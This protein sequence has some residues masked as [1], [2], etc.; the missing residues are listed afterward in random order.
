VADEILKQAGESM[1][2]STENLHH[3][4]AGIRTGKANPALLDTVKV[5]YYGQSVPLKQVA[6]IAVP[7]ARLITVQPWEKTLVPEVE[8]AIQ[9]SELGLNPQSDGTLIRLPIPP[10]TEER[11]KELVKVVKRFAEESRVA[12]RNIR[13]DAN[14]RLKKL[15]KEHQ[16][17]EDQMH[18]RQDEVQKLTDRHV[19]KIDEIVVAKEKEI[20]EI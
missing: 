15:E 11:R 13:R 1:K 6:N 12:V 19:A 17:S 14:D 3:E 7:E 5:M 18:D 9:A 2:K 16:I 8:K 20:M 10:L 4:L